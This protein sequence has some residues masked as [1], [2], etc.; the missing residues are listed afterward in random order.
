MTRTTDPTTIMLAWLIAYPLVHDMARGCSIRA[1]VATAVA[2]LAYAIAICAHA[3]SPGST[4]VM[5]LASAHGPI[6]LGSAPVRVTLSSTVEAAALRILL[7]KGAEKGTAILRLSGLSARAQPGV[8]YRIYFGLVEGA[9]PDE[10]HALGTI[11]FFNVVPLPGARP[12]P[13]QPI[14]FKV[15][16]QLNALLRSGEATAGLAVAVVPQGVVQP[17]SSPTIGSI[18]LLEGI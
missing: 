10:R 6:T 4:A 8:T 12:K 17:G 9:V 15:A 7:A 14:D 3:H 11:N 1:A 16:D 13:D 2:I 5:V 18:E